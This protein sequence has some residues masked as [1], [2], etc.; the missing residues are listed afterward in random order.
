MAR[1]SSLFPPTDSP[2]ATDFLPLAPWCGSQPNQ[3]NRK[4]EKEERHS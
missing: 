3:Y 2:A 4:G 1:L